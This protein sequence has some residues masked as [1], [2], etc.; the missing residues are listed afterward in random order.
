MKRASQEEKIIRRFIHLVAYLSNLVE[1]L[2]KP[3]SQ[4]VPVSKGEYSQQ[5]KSGDNVI[6]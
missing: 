1:I 3:C 6:L 5:I 4:K 2:K